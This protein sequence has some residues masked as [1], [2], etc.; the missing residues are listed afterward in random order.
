VTGAPA[1]VAGIW[2]ED[3]PIGLRDVLEATERAFYAEALRR[4]GGNRSEAARLLGVQPPAFR[5]AVRE[6]FPDLAE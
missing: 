6:R 2:A 3:G 4:A 5:K 1:T